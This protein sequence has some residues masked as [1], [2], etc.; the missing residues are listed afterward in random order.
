MES[1]KDTF[2][3]R[4][5]ELLIDKDVP[6]AHLAKAMGT[7]PQAI[8]S[9]VKG[10]TTPDY[11]MLCNIADY[12][13]VSI[14]WLLG[15][16]NVQFNDEKAFIDTQL[17][18]NNTPPLLREFRHA[19]DTLENLYKLY[20]GDNFSLLDG[21]TLSLQFLASIRAQCEKYNAVCSEFAYSYADHPEFCGEF[22]ASDFM[23]HLSELLKNDS[24]CCLD[25]CSSIISELIRME[26]YFR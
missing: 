7:S 4:L 19:K 12:F 17:A 14:D 21:N 24:F 16:T 3:K 6:Q 11:D 5:Y 20:S 26:H 18:N 22:Y 13:G 10:K 9:Y 8:S 2:A 15:R 1:S 23:D 25:D